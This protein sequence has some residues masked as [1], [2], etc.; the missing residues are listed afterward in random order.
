[1]PATAQL[2]AVEH[3]VS[4]TPRPLQNR[5]SSIHSIQLRMHIRRSKYR[6]RPLHQRH[7]R[8]VAR[9]KVVVVVVVVVIDSQVLSRVRQDTGRRLSTS[10]SWKRS[11]STATAISKRSVLMLARGIR[12]RYELMF[13]STLCA[14][15][16]KPCGSKTL[17]GPQCNP[18]CSRRHPLRPPAATARLRLLAAQSSCQR[19]ASSF[20]AAERARSRTR[21]CRASLPKRLPLQHR[22]VTLRRHHQTTEHATRSTAPVSLER[23]RSILARR[24]GSRSTRY[25]ILVAFICCHL[26]HRRICY[27]CMRMA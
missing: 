2:R 12:H 14:S 17:A 5:R 27:R 13:R 22:P 3:L 9:T 4:T 25:Q 26:L 8:R 24:V 21:L 16:E 19:R 7:R 6:C 1:M 15:L 11:R 10:S 23:S 20:A 18:R